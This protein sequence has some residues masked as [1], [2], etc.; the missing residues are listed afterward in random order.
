[1]KNIAIVGG[2]L[3]GSSALK[4][5]LNH[6]Y[7]NKEDRI[8]VFEAQHTLGAGMPYEEDSHT[9]MLNN[10]PDAVSA[11][12][13][14]P[15][16]FIKWLD[17]NYEK[18]T[19]FEELVPR[20][21]YGEYLNEKFEPWYTHKQ[22]K[23]IKASVEDLKIMNSKKQE[24]RDGEPGPYFY[25]VYTAGGWL[26]EFF[27]AV[28]FAIGHPPY[29]D[30]YD[31]M[32]EENYIHDPYPVKENLSDF[33]GD[34][35]IG[36][37]GSGAAGVDVMRY[38]IQEQNLINPLT[39]YV[40]NE[41]FYTPLIPLER[42]FTNF[43]FSDEWITAELEKGKGLI[44]LNQI[45]E[46]IMDDFSREEVDLLEVYSDYKVGKL[47]QY[48]YALDARDQDLAYT[49]KYMSSMVPYLP[50]LINSL[51][52]KDLEIFNKKYREPMEFLRTITPTKTF[53]WILDLLQ[54]NDIRVV[55]GLEEINSLGHNGFNILADQEEKVDVLINVT[56]F[57]TRFSHARKLNPLIENLY[58]KKIILSHFDGEGILVTWP[59]LQP[60]NQ[61][62]GVLENIFFFGA[63]VSSTHYPNN[64]VENITRKSSDTVQYYMKKNDLE[65]EQK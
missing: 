59:G 16:D 50:A 30:Y 17:Q 55:R 7:F 54:T 38:L 29:S 56:G 21:V 45:Y 53:E 47:V 19:N 37:I 35:K 42:P 3:A 22:V 52:Q 8:T 32:G 4:E 15:Y 58:R 14:D 44:P 20:P 65:N 43:S 12:G 34:E 13:G 11:E 46:L 28:F 6:P 36:I 26:G 49:Q 18:R 9:V 27:D 33:N 39:F 2:G 1:M 40:R 57:E 62:Y 24:V 64:H 25:D 63:F 60:I 23:V 48:R 31:L 51:N 61:R 41:P 5:L 10:S